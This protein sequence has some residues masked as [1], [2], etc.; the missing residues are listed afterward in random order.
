MEYDTAIKKK[1]KLLLY[2]TTWMKITDLMM[3]KRSLQ[4]IGDIHVSLCPPG[5]RGQD[6][7]SE[8]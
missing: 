4:G 1:D 6:K 8:R 2:A 5:R 3:S 7:M